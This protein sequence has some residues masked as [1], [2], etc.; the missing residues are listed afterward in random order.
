MCDRGV[1]SAAIRCIAIAAECLADFKEQSEVLTILEKIRKETGWRI[2]FLK[3]ELKKKWGWTDE[4]V[5]QQQQQQQMENMLQTPPLDFSFQAAQT[6]QQPPQQQQPVSQA[7]P[8][9]MGPS[10]TT[11]PSMPQIPRGIVNP[12]MR[13]ADFTGATHPYP[14]HYVPPNQPNNDTHYFYRLV[15]GNYH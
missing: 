11:P 13:T 2:D 10:P 7:A 8:S 3:P 4:Y 15:D 12:L 1:A 6:Q 9:T 14:N 5:R